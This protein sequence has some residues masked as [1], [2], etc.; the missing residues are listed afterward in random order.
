MFSAASPAVSII[1]ANYNYGRFLAEAIESALGQTHERVEVVV[2][3]DGSTDDSRAVIERYSGRVVAVLKENG[4]QASA[5]NHG[6][7]RAS[8][9]VVIFLDADDVLDSDTAARVAA[10]FGRRRDLAKVH[11]RLKL[12]DGD[13]RPMG[14]VV[15]PPGLRLPAGDLRELARLHPDDV[16]YPPASGNAFAAWALTQLMP[17]PEEDYR[18]L[19]DVYLLNLVPLLGPV[20]VLEGTGGGYR[21]HGA[22]S[23]YASCLRLDRVRA[24]IQTTHATHV[25]MRELAASLGLAGFP[26]PARDDRSLVFLSQRL[27]SRKLDPGSHPF[28][29]DS[30]IRLARRGTAAALRRADLALGLRLVY[31]TWFLAMAVAPGLLAT[32]LAE[33]MLYSERR[34]RLSAFIERL[35]R[36]R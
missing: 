27:I 33:Q 19:A 8:G 7:Q 6:F 15:P 24:T 31:G 14:E 3:D 34:G 11:Y 26:E 5:F 13:G 32:W 17:M 22:N 1:I 16:P 29:G 21:V 4:G 12:I 20:E 30:L 25:H 35:R 2:V 36:L 10:V 18:L 23:H 9:D 28:A